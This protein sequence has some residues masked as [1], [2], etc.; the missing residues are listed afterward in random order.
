MSRALI[1]LTLLF[2]APVFAQ[3]RPA[4][5]PVKVETALNKGLGPAP[6]DLDRSTPRNSWSA[7]VEACKNRRWERGMHLLNLGDLPEAERKT[8]GSVLTSQLCE[9]LGIIDA[10]SADHLDDTS[11]GPMD[12]DKARNYAAVTKVNAPSGGGEIW[13]RKV[14][15]RKSTAEEEKK[16]PIEQKKSAEEEKKDPA[17]V[18]ESVSQSWMVTRKTVSMIQSWYQQLVKKKTVKIKEVAAVIPGLGAPLKQAKLISPRASATQFAERTKGGHYDRAAQLL[19]LSQHLKKTSKKKPAKE[20]KRLARRLSLVLKRVHPGGYGRLSNDPTGAPETGVPLDEEVVV[21]TTLDGKPAQISLIRV[22]RTDPQLIWIYSADTVSI[23]D[24]L[25]DEH[26]YGWAGDYLPPLFFDWELL[27]VQL[28]QWLGLLGLGLV[29]LVFG[30]IASF[31]TRKVLLH[32][33]TFTKWDWDDEIVGAMNGPLR[34]VYWVLG[35]AIGRTF[36][37]LADRADAFVLASCKLLSIMAAGWFLLRVTDMVGKIML[38]VFKDRDD[39][40]IVGMVPVARKIVKALIVAI[41]VIFALQNMGMDV[42]SL[43]AGLGIGGLAFALAAKTTLENLLGG[44]TIAFDRPFKVGDYIKVGSLSGTVEDLGLRSTRIRT[45]NRTIITVPNGQIVDSKVENYAPR[46]RMRFVGTFGVQ[47]DTSPDQIRFI[48]DEFKRY[49]V[50]HERLY[51]EDWRVRF[52]GFGD[53]SQDIEVIFYIV[54]SSFGEYTGIREGIL[55]DL[56]E[57]ISRAGAE[58]AY[59]SQTVYTGKDSHADAKKAKEAAQ[60]VATRRKAGELSL[61]EIPD[62]VR[63][64]LTGKK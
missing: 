31:L 24:R 46:D 55:F 21:R 4:S 1:A 63:A 61:P 12:E 54:T 50:G 27:D 58:F 35:F 13:L 38:R 26:G 62:V 33:A 47:Y 15:E 56:G 49:L 11:I 23:I 32:L 20:G 45:P 29:C 52:V 10:L 8:L 34:M 3:N 30:V 42:G 57:I 48:I 9:V 7:F 16:G 17:E 18:K 41:V 39:D 5:I 25:Y 40:M 19:E 53:S 60:T 6:S 22:R 28:W 14:E 64:Q 36:L 43:L 51:P 44:I 37:S 2:S 59:P